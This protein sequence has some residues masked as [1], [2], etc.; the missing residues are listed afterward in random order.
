VSALAGFTAKRGPAIVGGILQK[1]AAAGIATAVAELR[2]IGWMIIQ[3]HV[4]PIALA[5][6]GNGMLKGRPVAGLPFCFV[7]SGLRGLA[8]SS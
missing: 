6:D 3:H 8:H 5:G 1:A 7:G 4:N 2:R